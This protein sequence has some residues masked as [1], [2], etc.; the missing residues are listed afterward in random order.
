MLAR[1]PVR[2]AVAIF[3]ARDEEGL[4][5]RMKKRVAVGEATVVN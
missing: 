5:K 4:S 1:P 3:Q 2:E